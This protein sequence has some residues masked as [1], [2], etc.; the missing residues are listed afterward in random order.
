MHPG[1]LRYSLWCDTTAFRY[2]FIWKWVFPSSHRWNYRKLHII[3]QNPIELAWMDSLNV[4]SNLPWPMTNSKDQA[5]HLHSGSLLTVVCWDTKHWLR[6]GS[7]ILLGLFLNRQALRT[8]SGWFREQ[9]WLIHW[10]PKHYS[11][12]RGNKK[13]KWSEAPGTAPW[14]WLCPADFTEEQLNKNPLSASSDDFSSE[15]L[16]HKH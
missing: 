14:M 3:Y 16:V 2:I 7:W 10:D 8:T 13:E 4:L 1:Y 12:Y 11:F 6:Q 9:Y 15:L 5:C